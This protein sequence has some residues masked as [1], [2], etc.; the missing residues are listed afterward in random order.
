MPRD[1]KL[2]LDDILESICRIYEYVAGMDFDSF[3]EDQKTVDAVV[4]NLEIIAEAAR[5]LPSD[6]KNSLADIQWNKIVALRNILTHE[7]F[8]VNKEIVWDV[9]QTKLAAL[10]VACEKALQ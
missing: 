9:V 5:N 2:Y 8:G 6:L 10:K 3:S 4:R 7:Y 1:I